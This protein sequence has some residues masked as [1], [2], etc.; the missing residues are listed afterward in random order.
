MNKPLLRVFL[1]YFVFTF[2]SV[3]YS[4]NRKG[5]KLPLT[6]ILLNL[7]ARYNVKFSFETKTVEGI[8]VGKLYPEL[9]LNQALKQLQIL[10]QLEFKILNDRFIAITPPKKN[11]S[12]KNIQQLEEVVIKNYLA[13][14]ISKTINGAINVKT[15]AFDILPGVI[16]PDVLQIVESLPSIVSVDERISNLNIRGG[17]NDQNLIVYEGI[18][19]Y[20]SGHFFG[21]ISAFNPYLSEDITVSKNGTSAKFGDGV[22]SVISIKNSDSISGKLKAG[23]G[24]NLLSVDGFAKI[25]LS[26]KTELQLSARRST[27]DVFTSP[28]YNSY[29]ERIFKDSELNTNTIANTLKSEDERFF[30][31]DVNAKFLYDINKTSKLRFNVLTLFNSLNYNQTFIDSNTELQT[32]KSTKI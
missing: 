28:T 32:R 13:K 26:K 12:S 1:Y 6:Q 27:T 23:F 22:S 29:F 24:V 15:K 30:F 9:S 10:T 2:S 8:L 5:E 18:R 31:Y 3:S 20:Q 25:P 4:Q 7:E 17:T 21:L 16:E 14:G 19:L 11:S